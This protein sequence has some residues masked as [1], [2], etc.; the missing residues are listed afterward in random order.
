MELY[1]IRHTEVH[2]PD[3]LCYGNFDIP[4]LK[5][6]EL[7]SD[8]LFYNL[9]NNIDQIF[10]SPSKRCTDLLDYQNVDFITKNELRELDFGDWEGKKWDEI[11]QN[12][13]NFWMED[14][15]N[16]QPKNGEKMIDL[17]N[18]SIK[19]TYDVFYLNHKKILFVTH[20]GVIR[21]LLSEALDINLRN[22]FDIPI[23]FNEIYK[24]NFNSSNKLSL[25]FSSKKDIETNYTT[26][27]II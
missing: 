27:K 8:L 21:A 25:H 18:R 6:Y 4:L 11:N 22:I 24:F 9:P 19:F 14:Y 7:K 26:K 3:N 5:D 16:R 17:Y 15:V 2:N 23:K 12:D 13:L 20:S 10:S 1:V